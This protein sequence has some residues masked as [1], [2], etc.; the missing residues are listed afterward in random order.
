MRV[1]KRE[2]DHLVVLF[3]P[4]ET[5]PEVEDD[6][7]ALQAELKLPPGSREFRLVY[8][9]APKDPGEIAILTRSALELLIELGGYAE[10]PESDVAE[11]RTRPTH[12]GEGV[13]GLPDPLIRIRSGPTK[14]GDAFASVRFRDRWYW[15]DDRDLPSKRTLSF[16]MLMMS[17]TAGGVAGAAPVVTVSAGS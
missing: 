12:T 3:F 13:D 10:V 8:G 1:E 7:R 9:Q 15:I 2:E 6:L 5:S 11:G 17:L 4:T 16:A 14:P